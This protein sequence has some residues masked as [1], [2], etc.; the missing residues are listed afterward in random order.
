M[1]IGFIKLGNEPRLKASGDSYD[2][3]ACFHGRTIAD[4]CSSL[5]AIGAGGNFYADGGSTTTR[6]SVATAN[7]GATTTDGHLAAARNH[8]ADERTDIAADGCRRHASR[9]CTRLD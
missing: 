8:S 5:W 3:S 6:H 4:H 1:N 9:V 2:H 7:F